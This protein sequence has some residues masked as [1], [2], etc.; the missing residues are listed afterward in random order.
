MMPV[1]LLA[2]NG[3]PAA[4]A[5][6]SL[7]SA[8]DVPKLSP[9]P[10]FDALTKACY[11]HVPAVRLYTYAAPALEA[12]SSLA[13][14]IPVVLLDSPG[15]PAANVLPSPDSATELPNIS[16]VPVFDAFT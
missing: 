16:K 13:G 12:N 5:L 2:S 1:V 14:F 3:A 4:S 11:D 10:V 8:T 15:D 9:A 6:P 7:D